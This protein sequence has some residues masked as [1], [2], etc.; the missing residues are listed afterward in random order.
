MKAIVCELCGSND[1]IKEEGIF[2]CQHCGTKYSL[3]EA[4]KLFEKGKVDVSGSTVK[5]DA[6]EELDNLYQLARRA[7]R[8]NN[9]N[10]A[11]NYYDQILVKDPN[12]WE[13]A[14]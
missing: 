4:K 7:R 5:I 6:Q 2:V 11:S 10:N 12:S 1:L 9:Y 8:E 13:A 3:E 14:F